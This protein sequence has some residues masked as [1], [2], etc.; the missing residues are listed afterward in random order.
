MLL[1]LLLSLLIMLLILL[2]QHQRHILHFEIQSFNEIQT[3]FDIYIHIPC[4]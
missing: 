1:I 4:Q 2:I 3:T